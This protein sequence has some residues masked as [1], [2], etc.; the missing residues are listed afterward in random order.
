MN[1]LITGATG[2]IGSHLCERLHEQNFVVHAVGNKGRISPKCTQFYQLNLDGIPWNMLPS[3][4]D[5]CIHQAANNFTQDADVANMIQSNVISPSNMFY[6]LFEERKCRQFIYASS[7]SVYGNASVPQT[8]FKTKLNPLTPY[9]KSK[10]QFEQFAQV[11]GKEKKCSVVGLRYSNVYGPNEFL[12][13]KRASMIYQLLQ[14]VLKN[15]TPK[16]FKFGE[17][18]RD[19]VYVD[20]VVNANILALNYKDTNIFNVGSGESVSMNR[21]LELINVT[22]GKKIAAEYID[23]NISETYQNE[24]RLD[25]LHSKTFLGYQPEINAEARIVNFVKNVTKE[26][27]V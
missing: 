11:F 8:E 15:Q 16:L 14:N 9:A 18:K 21:V 17:H 20:D 19:W 23:N 25:L 13:E 26:I 4:I 5:V 3:K 2:F 1:I 12:K 22:L 7:A 10:M 27:T 24:S 6:R